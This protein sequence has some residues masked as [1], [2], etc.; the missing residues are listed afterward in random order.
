[1]RGTL[2]FVCLLFIVAR[3]VTAVCLLFVLRPSP[4]GTFSAIRLFFEN[5]CQV[6][7]ALFGRTKLFSLISLLG[8][9]L[10]PSSI[11]LRRHLYGFPYEIESHRL[12]YNG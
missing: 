1:M 4:P 6:N 8:Y 3:S 2:P 12:A 7:L 11:L 5:Q 10:F 9:N